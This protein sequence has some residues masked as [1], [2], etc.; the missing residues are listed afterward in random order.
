MV[1]AARWYGRQQR[2][3]VFGYIAQSQP[4]ELPPGKW[5]EKGGDKA[6]KKTPAES[7][8]VPKTL[9]ELMM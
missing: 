2:Q 3:R 6:R 1:G 8:C 5:V 4:A 9:S 7:L